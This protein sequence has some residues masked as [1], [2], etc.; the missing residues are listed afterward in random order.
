MV[1]ASDET[2]PSPVGWA[3]AR[4]PHPGPEPAPPAPPEH[5]W[6]LG[7]FVVA[8]IVF[9]GTSV[10]VAFVLLGDGPVSTWAL[11]AALG[12]PSVAAAAVAILITVVRGNGPFVDLRLRWSAQE[13]GLGLA[14]GFGGLFVT[15]PAAAVYAWLVGDGA[16]SAVGD[17]FGGVT[18]SQA[19]ALLVAVLV[20]IVVPVCEEILYRG[21]LWRGVSRLGAN[22]WV[23]LGVVTLIFALAHFEWPRALLLLVVSIPLGLAR[24][25]TD[26]LLAPMV[27]HS[28]NNLIPGIALY[29][30]L[31]G[32]FP[33]VV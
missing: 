33:A 24:I 27:A 21:L 18:A 11:A 4:P 25:Y 13:F 31:T 29:L 6:G 14:F 17:I 26:G 20:V 8:E 9:L 3:P 22:A 28:M 7:A 2:Q 10:L 12:V 23:T 1:D 30:T 19:E 16:N 15:L 32:A 5:R